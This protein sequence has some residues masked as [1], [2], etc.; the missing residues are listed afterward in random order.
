MSITISAIPIMFISAK[1]LACAAAI[2]T[3]ATTAANTAESIKIAAENAKIDEILKQA[4]NEQMKN[5]HLT[6][7]DME[8]LSKEYETPF[9]DKDL[10]V[11]TLEEYGLK[12]KTTENNLIVAKIER[13]TIN[14]SREE[15]N[16]PYRMK[17]NFP[18]DC[19]QMQSELVKDIY[20]EYGSNTQEEV[21]IKIK[22]KIAQSNMYIEEEE[23]L[24]DDSIV[25]TI[26][27]NWGGNVKKNKN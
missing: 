24:D 9:M 26:D 20:D 6:K 4:Q 17:I 3:A 25:L 2:T 16:L 12:I 18:D 7:E 23:V 27:I 10:L 13:V 21:Y 11:R 8:L 14:F 22:E 15:S 19:E 1:I 5:I